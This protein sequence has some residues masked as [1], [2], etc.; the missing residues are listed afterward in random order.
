[1]ARC[2]APQLPFGATRIRLGSEV[3]GICVRRRLPSDLED[4]ERIA[5]RVHATDGYPPYLPNDDFVEFLASPDAIGAW[6]A[7]RDEAIVG[8]VALHGGSSREVINLAA[9]VMGVEPARLGVV[10]RLLVS[11]DARRSGIGRLLLE[12][13]VDE[14]SRR[15]LVS[16]LDVTVEFEA[17]VALYE[18]SGWQR[19][20]TTE[21][22][23]A[24]GTRIEEFVYLAPTTDHT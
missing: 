23:L 20:G 15:G 13:A 22:E 17:A 19:L 14:A 3:G 16:I 18:N 4:C 7:T 9:S 8:H 2:Q 21:V 5:R 6:V 1:V 10:A 12:H 24:D 11:P